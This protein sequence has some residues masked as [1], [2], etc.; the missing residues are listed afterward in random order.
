M[1]NSSGKWQTRGP[2]ELSGPSQRESLP[3]CRVGGFFY[4]H[5]ARLNSL[6]G[7]SVQFCTDGTRKRCQACATAGVLNVP[8]LPPTPDP[9]P[10]LVAPAGIF[11]PVPLCEGKAHVGSIHVRPA[12]GV[13][14]RF[15]SG[16]S[17]L[18]RGHDF[19]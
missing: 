10:R 14:S 19:Y 7:E 3:P 2:Q 9:G 1:S 5:A 6:V 11:F 4:Q 18:P 15:R 8:P 12:L 16:M 13:Q 17:R